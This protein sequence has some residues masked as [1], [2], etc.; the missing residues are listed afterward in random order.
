MQIGLV[1]DPRV[2]STAALRDK[3]SRNEAELLMGAVRQN[4]LLLAGSRTALVNDMKSA[5]EQLDTRLGQ[6][7]QIRIEEIAKDAKRCIAAWPPLRRVTRTWDYAYIRKL[8]TD[9]RA[10]AIVC[11]TCDDMAVLRELEQ[12]GIEVVEIGDYSHS[13]T[14][15]RRQ[16]YR[17]A[18]RLDDIEDVK[19][20]DDFVGRAIKYARRISLIDPYI[21]SSACKGRAEGY[22]SAIAYVAELW[23]RF[24]PYVAEGRL[25]LELVTAGGQRGP[26]GGVIDAA[27]ARGVLETAVRQRDQQ[28]I[29][30]A[31]QIT[32]KQDSTPRIFCDR[33]LEAKRRCW[34]VR[35]SIDC[36][37][38]LTGSSSRRRPTFIDP[39][40]EDNLALVMQF[41]DLPDA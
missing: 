6:Q 24:S 32:V 19:V 13:K 21:A 10:D 11:Q 3:H 12:E 35:H 28:Q 27:T 14:E 34:G 17:E 40:S 1:V 5:V 15:T 9:F 23:Q 2:F 25:D 33:F 20:R 29:I 30:G 41:R 39:A 4:A 36:L 31:L 16:R 38:Y 22:V 37:G 8:A 7:L 26:A 18:V